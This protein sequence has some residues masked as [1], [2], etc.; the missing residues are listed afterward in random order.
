M[1]NEF[2]ILILIREKEK[3]TKESGLQMLKK[4]K[5]LRCYKSK[6]LFTRTHQLLK[7]NTQVDS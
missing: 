6:A 1:K 2:P 3:K 7:E 5:N 4:Y